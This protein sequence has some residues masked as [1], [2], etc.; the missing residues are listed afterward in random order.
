MD[1]TDTTMQMLVTQRL[2]DLADQVGV[3]LSN[4]DRD[5]AELLKRE[6]MDLAEAYDDHDII[7]I[8]EALF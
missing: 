4:G 1:M 3:H 2:E 6:G 8:A 7:L 5:L